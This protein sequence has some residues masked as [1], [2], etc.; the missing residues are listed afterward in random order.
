[1]VSDHFNTVAYR[2]AL[3]AV[4][5]MATGY[6]WAPVWD[7]DYWWHLASGR[8]IV[9]NGSL[10]DTDPFGVYGTINYWGK[11]VLKGQWL[12]QLGLYGAFWAGEL[13]GVITLR[14]FLLVLCVLTL[15][16][17]SGGK[18]NARIVALIF[19]FLAAMTLRGHTADRP[20]L[21]SFACFA[22]M[23]IPLER[24][25]A[26][27][28][29]RALYPLPLLFLFWA[30]T[31]P[32][33]ILGAV[34]LGAFAFLYL[35]EQRF[36]QRRGLWTKEARQLLIIFVLCSLA[37]IATPN[38]L[39]SYEYLFK[40]EANNIQGL[41]TEY[42][43]PFGLIPKLS[44][45]PFL[46]YYWLICCAALATLVLL[47][48]KRHFVEAGLTVLITAIS[49]TAYRYVPFMVIYTVPLI[50]RCFGVDLD[51]LAGRA[52]P[53]LLSAAALF[54]MVFLTH[55][56]VKGIAFRGGFLKE[57]YPVRF[58]EVVQ[59]QGLHGRIFNTLSWGGYL[60][61]ELWPAASVFIDGRLMDLQK[62][63]FYTHVLWM[64]DHGRQFFEQSDFSMVMVTHRNRF[65]PDEQ[66]YPLIAYLRRHPQWRL[67]HNDETGV[68][69][70]RS[71]E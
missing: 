59:R 42:I 38:G 46:P 5:A 51:R 45:A 28:H 6:F 21:F 35:I 47:V 71:S 16:Y 3:L 18:S 27:A 66:P 62:V 29:Q 40:L 69:F 20:Q 34:F 19:L 17:R 64:T 25:H 4:L 44:S 37:T 50:V 24:F 67:L 13:E 36:I 52:R 60:T 49:F 9:E 31:H 22:L 8:Y 53:W 33:A 14:A 11:T 65:A 39:T 61:W 10:P 55:G 54:F 58:I 26:G 12:G 56:I 1:M 30:N 23:L 2:L 41:I 43:S 68:L 57:R 48:R 70:A 63:E 15:L 32:G 7:T